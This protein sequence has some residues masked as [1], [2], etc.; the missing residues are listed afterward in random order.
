MD[1]ARRDY[2]IKIGGPVQGTAAW[3]GKEAEGGL[4]H[5]NFTV[6]WVN[7]QIQLPQQQAQQGVRPRVSAPSAITLGLTVSICA[8][9]G[10]LIGSLADATSLRIALTRLTLMPALSPLLFRKLPEP[11]APKFRAVAQQTGDDTDAEL[12]PARDHR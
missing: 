9:V 6:D 2:E 12:S 8:L 4:A 1:S 5:E 7:Q 3:Q 10:P 11:T